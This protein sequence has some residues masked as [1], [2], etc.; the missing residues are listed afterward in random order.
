MATIAELKLLIDALRDEVNQITTRLGD[1]MVT[2]AQVDQQI[3][4]AVTLSSM[5]EYFNKI[6]EKVE[7][8]FLVTLL[9]SKFV[10]DY[11]INTINIIMKC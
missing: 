2:T 9:G 8:I 5:E 11:L 1:H 3:G 7:N 4:A 6:I 10:F